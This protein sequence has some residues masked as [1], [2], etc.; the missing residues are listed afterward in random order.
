M[1]RKPESINLKDE[2]T[3]RDLFKRFYASACQFA[4]HF[5][6]DK[7]LAADM[8]Q[9]S[10]LYMWEH[11]QVLENEMAFKSYLYHCVKNKCLNYIRDHRVELSMQD[12][13]EDWEDGVQLDHWIIENDLRRRI[14]EEINKL[15]EV[16]REIMLMRLE[17]NSFEE[18]SKELNLNINTLKTNK[19]QAYRELRLRLADLGNCIVLLLFMF[20]CV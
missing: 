14:L 8:A 3:F 7:M 6:R 15:P 19:K 12:L 18:I 13:E 16:R 2:R 4:R 11:V 9:E 10:F 5:L 17:G 1:E 20:V